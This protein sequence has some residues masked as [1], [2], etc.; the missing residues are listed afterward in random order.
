MKYSF[1]EKK[2]GIDFIANLQS[3]FP[4]AAHIKCKIIEQATV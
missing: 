1:Q 2:L 4:L 3:G